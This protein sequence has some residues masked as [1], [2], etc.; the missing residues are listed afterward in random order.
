MM[1]QVSEMPTSGQFVAVWVWN[2]QPWSSAYRWESGRLNVYSIFDDTMEEV[3][4]PSTL[5]SHLIRNN[6]Q[7]FIAD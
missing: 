7:F 1:K 6:A 4:H 5:K 3:E 2:N